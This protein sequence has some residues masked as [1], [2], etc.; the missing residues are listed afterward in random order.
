MATGT[1]FSLGGVGPQARRN[2]A[3]KRRANEDSIFG[4]SAFLPLP[5][6]ILS[7]YLLRRIRYLLIAF[8]AM[9]A[10]TL[11]FW[12]IMP[13]VGGKRKRG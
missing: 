13:C 6:T 9:I 4:F 11:N 3:I 8:G 5:I 1:L 7:F 10:Y 2:R 12:V